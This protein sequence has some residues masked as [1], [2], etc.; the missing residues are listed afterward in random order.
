MH[1]LGHTEQY[2][3][4]H[5]RDKN[6]Q[7]HGVSGL[8]GVQDQESGPDIRQC[9]SLCQCLAQPDHDVGWAPCEDAL[10][11]PDPEGYSE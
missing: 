11:P 9:L 4:P 8:C 7:S 5:L 10:H 1:H 2:Y 3:R 6:Y